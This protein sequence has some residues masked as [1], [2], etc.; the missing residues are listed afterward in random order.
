MTNEWGPPLTGEEMKALKGRIDPALR[1]RFKTHYGVGVDKFSNIKLISGCL[2][3]VFLP[4][5][6][7]YYKVRGYNAKH[8]DKPIVLHCGSEAKHPND[9]DTHGFVL[10]AGSSVLCDAAK[11][12]L[13]DFDQRNWV[14]VI[15]YT[16][17]PKESEVTEQMPSD[18]AIEYVLQKWSYNSSVEQVKDRKT[19]WWHHVIDHARLIQQYEPDRLKPAVDVAAEEYAVSEWTD[20]WEC[21]GHRELTVRDFKAGA[22]WQRGQG[23]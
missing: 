8:P 9:Y 7:P 10:Y 11:S 14:H 23:L 15:A 4:A 13:N 6:H 17:K 12:C 2:E 3:G 21:E 20:E 5:N 22:A 16:P 1:V 19:M 18:E